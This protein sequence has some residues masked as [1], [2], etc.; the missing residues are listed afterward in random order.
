M[1][2]IELPVLCALM[3][4]LYLIHFLMLLL[5]KTLFGIMGAFYINLDIKKEH[6]WLRLMREALGKYLELGDV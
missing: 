3:D 2:H 1:Q 6:V 4:A 5:K